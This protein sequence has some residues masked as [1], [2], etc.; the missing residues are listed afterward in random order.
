[1]SPAFNGL[2]GWIYRTPLSGIAAGTPAFTS[3]GPDIL[4]R[5]RPT[6][7]HVSADGPVLAKI[8][9]QSCSAFASGQPSFR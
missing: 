5:H 2:S 6:L 8:R 3:F 7:H 9:Q 1:M 4:N